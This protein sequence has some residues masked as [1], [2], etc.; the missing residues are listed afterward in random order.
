M[1]IDERIK[2]VMEQKNLTI[3]AFAESIGI[4]QATLSHIFNGRNKPSMNVILALYERYP[5]VQ[6]EWLLT[7]KGSMYKSDNTTVQ[8]QNDYQLPLFSGIGGTHS[9]DTPMPAEHEAPREVVKQEIVYRD[10]PPR[11]IMEIR[12]FFDD[13]TYQ[14]LKPEK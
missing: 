9:T 14:I 5:D 7:G 4:A 8:A 13:D 11:K 3:G 12:I 10:K 6:L 2:L 1:E